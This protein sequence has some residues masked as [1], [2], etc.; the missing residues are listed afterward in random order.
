VSVYKYR[1]K[2]E[3]LCVRVVRSLDTHQAQKVL[4]HAASQIR[5]GISLPSSTQ[6]FI[7]R[8]VLF[9][10]VCLIREFF[11]CNA[12]TYHVPSPMCVSVTHKIISKIAGK[13]SFHPRA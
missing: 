2:L 4:H 1:S 12:G 5:I 7:L 6:V 13:V 3:P 9:D 8:G 10:R 11:F